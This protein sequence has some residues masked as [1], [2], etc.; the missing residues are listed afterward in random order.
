MIFKNAMSF[1]MK[2][3]QIALEKGI[4]TQQVQQNYLI[5][6]FLEK[7]AQSE[8]KDNFILKGG[9]LIGKIVGLDQRSQWI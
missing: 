2:I 9:F 3:K 1:K 5:E 6:A 8:F 7:L 4:S